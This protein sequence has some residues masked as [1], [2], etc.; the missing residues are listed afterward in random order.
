MKCFSNMI[1]RCWEDNN[2]I[3]NGLIIHDPAH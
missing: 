1:S 2:T 3:S